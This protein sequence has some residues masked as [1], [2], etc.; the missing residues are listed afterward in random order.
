MSATTTDAGW[1]ANTSVPEGCDDS[2]RSAAS[3]LLDDICRLVTLPCNSTTVGTTRP[4]RFSDRF[5]ELR[6]RIL[7]RISYKSGRTATSV[8]WQISGAKANQ[9]RAMFDG[10]AP[11]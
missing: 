8:R 10:T 11:A 9:S 7:L 5:L 4:C 1:D 6:K 2:S 3:S